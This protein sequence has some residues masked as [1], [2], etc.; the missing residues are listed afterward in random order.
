[1]SKIFLFFTIVLIHYSF[2][3][4]LL[5]VYVHVHNGSLLHKKIIFNSIKYNKWQCP[6]WCCTSDGGQIR[7]NYFSHLT[8]KVGSYMY[9]FIISLAKQFSKLFPPK[10]HGMTNR[11]YFVQIPQGKMKF[12]IEDF[13]LLNFT[14][15]NLCHVI[16]LKDILCL[17]IALGIFKFPWGKLSVVNLHGTLIILYNNYTFFWKYNIIKWYY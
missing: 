10:L 15:G 2:H 12:S 3:N 6:G 13:S 4:E 7:L 16:F 17:I 8:V 14:I 11:R 9:L 5:T 1:M